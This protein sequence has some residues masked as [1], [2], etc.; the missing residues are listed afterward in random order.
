MIRRRNIGQQ[1][2]FV[3]IVV[4]CGVEFE[5]GSTFQAEPGQGDRGRRQVECIQQS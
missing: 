2:G 1:Q 3:G 5:I 4:V